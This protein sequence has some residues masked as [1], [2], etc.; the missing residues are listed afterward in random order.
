MASEPR[1]Q[2]FTFLATMTETS[3]CSKCK[4][5]LED[6]VQLSPDLLTSLAV[7]VDGIKSALTMVLSSNFSFASYNEW[8]TYFLITTTLCPPALQGHPRYTAMRVNFNAF[9]LVLQRFI[10]TSNPITFENSPNSYHELTDLR[11]ITCGWTLL[12]EFI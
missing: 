6:S 3:H 9:S 5:F 1:A 10:W 12:Q 8:A 11:H 2:E 4:K 7:F